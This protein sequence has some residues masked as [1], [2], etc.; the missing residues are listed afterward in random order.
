MLLALSRSSHVD[1][2]DAI[3]SREPGEK[4]ADSLII[5]IAS[6]FNP[7]K[8]AELR[9]VCLLSTMSTMP[10][11]TRAHVFDPHAERDGD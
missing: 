11:L 5:Y 2:R 7:F 3:Y 10:Y 1:H 4:R 6:L 8:S 9:K